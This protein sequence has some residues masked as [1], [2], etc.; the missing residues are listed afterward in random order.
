MKE[1]ADSVESSSP[2]KVEYMKLDRYEKGIYALK[3]SILFTLPLYVIIG[4]LL[5]YNYYG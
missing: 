2:S 4:G 3:R 5:V 1:I